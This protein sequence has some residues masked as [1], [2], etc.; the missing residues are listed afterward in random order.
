[1]VWVY[2]VSE[3]IFLLCPLFLRIEC[4]GMA[5]QRERKILSDVDAPKCRLLDFEKK[6]F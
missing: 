6:M 2:Y 5:Y 3:N 4:D 1:M